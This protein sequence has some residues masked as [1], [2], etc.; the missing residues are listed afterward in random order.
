M[1]SYK[2]CKR[3]NPILPAAV[4]ILHFDGFDSRFNNENL[5][6]INKKLKWIK[7]EK[8]ILNVSQTKLLTS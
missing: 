3:I 2:G 7:E 1:K 5:N 6:V 8:N 4:E